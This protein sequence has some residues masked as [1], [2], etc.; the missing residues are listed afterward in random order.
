MEL[1]IGDAPKYNPVSTTFGKALKAGVRAYLSCFERF[2]HKSY[3]IS[4]S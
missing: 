4:D 1:R 3:G 2:N